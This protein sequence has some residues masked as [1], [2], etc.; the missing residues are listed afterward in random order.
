[1]VVYPFLRPL[2]SPQIPS[3]LTFMLALA[4]MLVDVALAF[5]GIH[6]STQ[7]TRLVTGTFFGVMLPFVVL[8]V[9]LGAVHEFSSRSTT[10]HTHTKGT[11]DA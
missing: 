9:Y 6:E 8:P 5:L 7:I 11:V 10:A 2:R 1:M 4:P 3:R